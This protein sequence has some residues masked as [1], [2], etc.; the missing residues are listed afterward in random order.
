[1]KTKSDRIIEATKAYVHT[2]VKHTKCMQ[3]HTVELCYK[4]DE[5]AGCRMY[6]RMFDR[7]TRLERS[8]NE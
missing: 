2:R 4:C 3:R 5:F 6:Q 1:M 7:W 8:V